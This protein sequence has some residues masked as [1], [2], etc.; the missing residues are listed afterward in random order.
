MDRRVVEVIRSKYRLMYDNNNN[1]MVLCNGVGEMLFH[2]PVEVKLAI[3]ESEIFFENPE[4][5]VSGESLIIRKKSP[6][7]AINEIRLNFAFYDDCILVGFEADVA[8]NSCVSVKSLVYFQKGSRGLFMVDCLRS[9]SPTPAHEGF[10]SRYQPRSDAFSISCPPPLNFCIGNRNG[11]VS[12]G[13]VD[14]PDGMAFGMTDQFGILAEDTGGNKRIGFSSTYKAPRLLMT[15]PEEEWQS[16]SLFRAKLIELGFHK[17][18]AAEDRDTPVWWKS[19]MVCTYG[20]EIMEFHY[21]PYA[22]EDWVHPGFNSKWFVEWVH[23]A[24]RRLGITDF[25]VILDVFWQ[26]R[27][28]ADP[29]PDPER[30]PDLREIIELCHERGHHVLLWYAP[31]VDK[32]DLGFEP[33]SKKFGVIT[34]TPAGFDNAFT[35]DFTHKNAREYLAYVAQQLFGSQE[36]QLNADG[37]KMDFLCFVRDPVK[38]KYQVP[39]LGMGIR[40][41]YKFYELFAS[42]AAKVKKHVLLDASVSDPRFEN[43]VHMNR[44][45]DIHYFWW[46]RELRARISSS[47]APRIIIDS[48]GAIMKSDWVEQT[49]IS[50][51]LYSTPSLYYIRKFHDGVAFSDEKMRALGRLLSLSSK[52]PDGVPIFIRCGSWQLLRYQKVMGETVEGKTLVLFD[53]KGTGYIFTWEDGVQSI[54]LHGRTLLDIHPELD[55]IR[56]EEDTL[57]GNWQSG[58]VYTCVV[59]E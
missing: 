42:E 48:D 23:E 58:V 36:G 8:A 1:R 34:D 29:F 9:F 30:F 40:E 25:T 24:E 28:S 52:K 59:E 15:F 47:A 26:K 20:D 31:F 27:F 35:I 7:E 18:I 11:L 54:H 33:A 22:T 38:A 21:N 49:Y 2:F 37:L 14:L 53:G 56:V 51:V 13:L 3:S 55:D 17:P 12:F 10:Y 19:P 41:L 44:L 50:A 5:Q 39:E 45:H 6:T 43:I 4:Y 46:E 32:L 16:L 57:T